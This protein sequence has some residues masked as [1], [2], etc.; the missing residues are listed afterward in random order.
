MGGSKGRRR[1]RLRCKALVNLRHVNS[2]RLHQILA[3]VLWQ[4][5]CSTTW[6]LSQQFID[7]KGSSL[8]NNGP[9]RHVKEHKGRSRFADVR[10]CLVTKRILTRVCLPA[11]ARRIRRLKVHRESPKRTSVRIESPFAMRVQEGSLNSV[12]DAWL[13]RLIIAD[14]VID[15][16]VVSHV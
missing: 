10:L 16:S 8:V 7:D 15:A 12:K 9:V 11:K 2:S 1:T 13:H 3:K 5:G 4:Q 6:A 14:L